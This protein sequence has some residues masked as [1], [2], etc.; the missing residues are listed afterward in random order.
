M[1]QTRADILVVPT[2][3]LGDRRPPLPIV[4]VDQL[5]R[6]QAGWLQVPLAV[7]TSGKIH[8]SRECEKSMTD[9]VKYGISVFR[10]T[11]K[12]EYSSGTLTL[13]H[14]R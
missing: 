12:V 4:F 2:S 1:K 14:L 3:F 9:V 13:C 6:R 7:S 11:K 10:A 8:S 5:T